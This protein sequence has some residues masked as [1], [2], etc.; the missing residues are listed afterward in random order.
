MA[1]DK[2]KH[3]DC[4]LN[5]HKIKKEQSLLDK[6]ITKKNEVK[7][8]LEEEYGADLY[9]PFNSGS[10]AKHTAVNK[11]FDFDLI[12]PFKRDAFATLEKMYTEVYD[13]LYEK[14][15]GDATIRKQKV[16]IG[17]EFSADADGDVIKIDVVPGRE[18]NKDQ[19]KDDSNLNLYVYSQFGKIEKG[20]ERLKTNVKAQIENV[21]GNAEKDSIR[22]MIKLLKVWKIYNIKDPKS[23]FLELITIKAFEEETIEGTLWERLKKIMEYIRDNVETVSL[24]DPGN[25]NNDVADTLTDSDKTVLKDD[26][27]YMIERIEENSDNITSYYRINPKFPCDDENKNSNGY[28]SKEDS[29]S[30]P[31]PTRYS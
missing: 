20:S 3:L 31:P 13:F 19:Y 27:K 21:K 24:P 28:G 25:R 14:Y 7:E 4:V 18:L 8:A 22:Q 12:A 6:H 17:L 1:T 9:A 23:F 5:S 2:D 11:K 15:K 26:M 30:V 10:Y 16:S 29:L